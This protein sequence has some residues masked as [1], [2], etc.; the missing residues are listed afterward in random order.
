MIKIIRKKYCIKYSQKW[1]STKISFFD[2]FRIVTYKQSYI[3]KPPLGFSKYDFYTLEIDLKQSIDQIFKK[4]SNT[5]KNEIRRAQEELIIIQV[6]NNIELFQEFFNEFAYSKGL[7]PVNINNL[8]SHENFNLISFA[9][10]DDKIVSAHYYL[11][12]NIA[13]RARLLY[14]ASLRFADSN[15]RSFIGRA[16]KLLH[17]EDMKYFKKKGIAIYDFG[18]ITVPP[19]SQEH[20]GINKFKE[21][22]GGN[23]EVY[24]EYNSYLFEILSKLS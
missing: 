2:I 4:F 22:F 8:Q 16:N 1:F 5:I 12:D 3:L 13:S 20:I 19:L 18:G 15:N 14:S 21:S 10:S 24:N 17:F 9:Y 23:Q 7:K 6:N 11:V